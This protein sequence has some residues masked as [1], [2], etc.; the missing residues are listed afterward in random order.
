VRALPLVIVG[1]LLWSAGPAAAAPRWLPPTDL[2][3]EALGD[4]PD[5]DVA[6]APGGTAVARASAGAP[7]R[8]RC[9][10][11]VTAVARAWASIRRATP[12]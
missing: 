11:A 10:R 5:V 8:R 6:V 12:R 4:R 7:C 9:R 3:G 2:A 1:L